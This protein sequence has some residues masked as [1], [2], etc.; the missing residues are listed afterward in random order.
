M[1]RFKNSDY[2]NLAEN[3]FY[4]SIV[5]FV[6]YFLPLLTV[7]YLLRTLGLEQF[8]IVTFASVVMVY[9]SLLVDYGFNLSGTRQV[10]V[11]VGD[12]NGLNIIFN[13]IMAV[14]IIF[15]I[16]SFLILLIILNL[17][18]FDVDIYLY[19][20]SFSV[21][22]GQTL[23]PVWFLQGLQDMK[24]ISML[25]GI[26]KIL[27]TIGTFVLIKNKD[28]YLLVPLLNSLAAI[29]VGILSI[30]LIRK[31]YGIKFYFTS[32][33]DIKLQLKEGWSV[34]ISSISINLYTSSSILIL[35]MFA[36][37]YTVGCFAA[38]DKIIQAIK[39]IMTPVSQALYP[40]MSNKFSVDSRSAIRTLKFIFIPLL[41]ISFM[42]CLFVN[43]FA[44]NIIKIV[45]GDLNQ[46]TVTLLKIMS[47]IPFFVLVSNFFGIQVLL[48]SGFSKIF[49]R[50][51]ILSALIGVVCGF[52]FVPIWGAY[53]SS[54][55][56]IIIEIFVA[57]LMIIS[58]T[59]N[60]H[61]R[62]C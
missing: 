46:L 30:H 28:D 17:N 45:I 4:L 32:C 9:F 27:F 33:I 13:T 7:P 43:I 59:K 57:I 31:K 3:I 41:V 47:F 56:L 24:Y 51:L 20:F 19:V 6:N 60:V 22:V 52:A 48:S 39:G 40:Y 14:K 53:A 18:I 25:N 23:F 16:F 12:R 36:N 49:S 55:L 34:F 26:A 58:V 10:A 54:Y 11:L 2:K 8:G 44:D 1:G 42:G 5:N 15:L 38:A 62:E 50:N 29:L 37:N 35:G 61:L 21:V